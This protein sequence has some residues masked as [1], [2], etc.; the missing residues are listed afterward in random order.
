MHTHLL[1]AI[2]IVPESVKTA[3]IFTVIIR[4][5]SR[6]HQ[7]ILT[8]AGIMETMISNNNLSFY[9]RVGENAMTSF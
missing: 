5:H 7:E 2:E 8:P 1:T 9:R 6:N 4:V 3:L